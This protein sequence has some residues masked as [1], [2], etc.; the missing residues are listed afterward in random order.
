MRILILSD[1]HGKTG[2]ILK[3]LEEQP[4]ATVIIHLGDCER[5][6]QSLKDDLKNK[7]VYQVSGNCDFYALEPDERA[8]LLGGV[9]IF[10]CHG[11]KYNV[12]SNLELLWQEVERRRCKVA[13]FG[14]THI[15]AVKYRDGIYL[16]N[17][18]SIGKGTR[19]SYGIIDIT[20]QGIFCNIIP[21]YRQIEATERKGI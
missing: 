17:P 14:H 12:K 1:S 6:M 2:N 9:P 20:T 5:D 16:M 13:L 11:H 8:E 18:G 21:L 19:P 4:T 15:P 10:I 3:A 7:Q